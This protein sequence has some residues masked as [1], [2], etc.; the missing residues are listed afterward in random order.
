MA[1][2]GFTA[3][4]LGLLK[5]DHSRI[6]SIII[7]YIV[8]PCVSLSAFQ[9]ELTETRIHGMLIALVGSI[10][11]HVI[12]IAA[13]YFL[14]KWRGISDITKASLIFTNAGNLIIPLVRATLGAEMT[15]YTCVFMLVQTIITWTYGV[16]LISGEKK[17]PWKKIFSNINIIAILAGLALFIFQIRIPALFENAVESVAGIIGP[18]SMSCLLV[19]ILLL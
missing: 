4:R 2:F 11:I 14:G 7:I 12:Y 3:V 16:I 6:L 9:V 13:A 5:A 17:T 18:L 15:I 19:K 8:T 1:C 10:I